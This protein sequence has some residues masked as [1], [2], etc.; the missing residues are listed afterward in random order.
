V[1]KEIRATRGV[2]VIAGRIFGQYKVWT[3]LREEYSDQNSKS[4]RYFGINSTGE[5]ILHGGRIS[6]SFEERGRLQNFMWRK[7]TISI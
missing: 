3:P 1:L 6:I 5:R 4:Y 2:E 7:V